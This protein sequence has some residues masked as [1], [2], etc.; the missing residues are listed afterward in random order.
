MLMLKDL[1]KLPMAHIFTLLDT[2]DTFL[3]ANSKH[4]IC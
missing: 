1:Y 3:H 2:R 4:I